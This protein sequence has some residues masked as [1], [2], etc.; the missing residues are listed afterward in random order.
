MANGV[1][2]CWS[3]VCNS[4]KVWRNDEQLYDRINTN[5]NILIKQLCY[6]KSGDCHFLAEGSQM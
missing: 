6:V 5:K 1:V 2:F 3:L 4:G